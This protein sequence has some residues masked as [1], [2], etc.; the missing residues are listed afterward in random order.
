MKQNPFIFCEITV[1]YRVPI[2]KPTCIQYFN[3]A[4]NS[5]HKFVCPIP[6]PLNLQK[7]DPGKNEIVKITNENSRACFN[8]KKPQ[9]VQAVA[10]IPKMY[11]AVVL[12]VIRV[13]SWAKYFLDNY[14]LQTFA[15]IQNIYHINQLD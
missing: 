9:K 3:S 10:L 5:L 13:D 1:I 2:D 14:L 12:M 4:Y 7:I 11:L 6:L 15:F 8:K